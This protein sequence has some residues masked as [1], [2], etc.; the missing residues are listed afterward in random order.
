MKPSGHEVLITG[1]AKGIGLALAKKFHAAGNDVTIVGRDRTALDGAA[2]ALQGLKTIRADITTEAGRDAIVASA[3]ETTVLVNNAGL[4]FSGEF[5][6]CS[7]RQIDLEVE[8]N[9]LA[10]MHLARRFL[11]SLLDRDEAAIINITSVLALVPKESSP[12]YCATKAALRSFTH[13]LRWQ[14]EATPVRVFEVLPPVVDTAMTAG[15]GKG[16][17]SPDVVADTVWPA[18][19]ADRQEIL[20][21]KARAA[22]MLVR[23]APGLAEK[24]VRRS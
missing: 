2:A 7:E 4:Q 23:L 22:A 18:Y 5:S 13:A 1:G 12:V 3:A 21:G 20:V 8:T 6:S 24:I 17:I 15:R 16:K 11:P 19:L 9:Q 10:P 14:L